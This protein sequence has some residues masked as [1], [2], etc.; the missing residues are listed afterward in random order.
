MISTKDLENAVL[1][2]PGEAIKRSLLIERKEKNGTFILHESL[3][4]RIVKVPAL[5]SR[6][7]AVDYIFNEDKFI[8][9]RYH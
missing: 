1:A 4:G 8:G 2:K 5:K 9:F 3:D 6:H 7:G